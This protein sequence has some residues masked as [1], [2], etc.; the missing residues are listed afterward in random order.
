M[1]PT[2]VQKNQVVS[3][4]YRLSVAGEVIDASPAGQPLQFIQGAGMIIPGLEKELYGM[5]EGESKD[6]VVQPRE[7]YGELNPQA[8]VRVERSRFAPDAPLE[9]GRELQVRAKNGQIL[10]GRIADVG[11][12]EVTLD[13][14]HPLA[15]KELTFAVKIVGLRAASPQELARRT[16]LPA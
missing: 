15:G 14:N 16:V 6:V 1:T 2:T 11:S 5:A 8:V 7:G 10:T 13:F 12:Q 4:D 3:M 9:L